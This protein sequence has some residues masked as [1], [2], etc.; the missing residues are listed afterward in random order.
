ML[1]YSHAPHFQLGRPLSYTS[2]TLI[3]RDIERRERKKIRFFR[4]TAILKKLIVEFF[5]IVAKV[6]EKCI[7]LHSPSSKDLTN[8]AIEF[9]IAAP[10]VLFII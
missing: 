2:F 8:L 7:V 6:C 9:K 5:Y 3:T 4:L 10:L 1:F